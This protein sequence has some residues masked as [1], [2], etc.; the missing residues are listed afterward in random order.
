MTS[1]AG[2]CIDGRLILMATGQ[3]VSRAGAAARKLTAAPAVQET[4]MTRRALTMPV[5]ISLEHAD[6]IIR[7]AI[8]M[9]E[10]GGRR[11]SVSVVN[12]LGHPVAGARMDGA[13]WFTLGVAHAKAQTA[14]AFSRPTE[15]VD[16]LRNDFPDLFRLIEQQIA[17]VPTTLGGGAPIVKDHHVIGAV[18]VAGGLPEVDIRIA[19]VAASGIGS[20]PDHQAGS[21]APLVRE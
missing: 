1:S 21:T 10:E 4:T 6:G 12:H 19:A 7:H 20:T 8:T 2:F 16:P 9:A 15:A 14:V 17:F 13:T 11:I 3:Q 18:G 5:E